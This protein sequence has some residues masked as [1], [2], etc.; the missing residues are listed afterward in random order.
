MGHSGEHVPLN[1]EDPALLAQARPTKANTT[2][3]RSASHAERDLRDLLNANRAQIE[4]LPPDATT[5]AGGQY[6]LQQSRMGFNSEF[7]ATAEPVTFSAVTWR[8]SRLTNGELHLMHFSP[9]L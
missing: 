6:T 4:A 3:Y 2:T 5:T 9:R 8:I 7:G 1:N